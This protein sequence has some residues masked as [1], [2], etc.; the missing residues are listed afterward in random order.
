[1]VERKELSFFKQ[2]R[3]INDILEE[4]GNNSGVNILKNLFEEGF[5]DHKDKYF[6]L[7]ERGKK[8]LK[9]LSPDETRAGKS[10][11]KIFLS[12]SH[13]DYEIAKNL[14]DFLE[15]FGVNLFLAHKD[16]EPTREWEKEIYK[17]LK[18]C[19]IFIPL[20]TNNF[21]DSKWTDQESG[22]AY[23]EN[24]KIIPLMIDL[25]PYGFLGKFQAVRTDLS[26]WNWKYN[27]SRVEI[28]DLIDKEFPKEMRKCIL[29]SLEKTH[30]WVLGKTKMR[31][32][33]DKEPFSREEINKIIKVSFGNNQIYNA[34]GVKEILKELIKKYDKE[35]EQ[36][37]KRIA[38]GILKENL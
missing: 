17:N 22:I 16:I 19:D 25:V 1:M 33:K 8:V 23:N 2:E 4:F 27:D 24:K 12:Y 7:N 32:L 34:E 35:I 11:L 5:I 10:T 14:K 37:I 31:I 9:R 28:I 21:K 36:P 15:S 29:N 18:E 20:L 13:K 3:E 26:K 38:M 6:Q 30:C